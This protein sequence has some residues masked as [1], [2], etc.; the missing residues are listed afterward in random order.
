MLWHSKL[1][2]DS[3]PTSKANPELMAH[4]Q[5]LPHH[6]LLAAHPPLVDKVRL[7]ADRFQSR[8][9]PPA[10]CII[11][12]QGILAALLPPL[13]PI[14]PVKL[15]PLPGFPIASFRFVFGS[16]L[17]SSTREARRHGNEDHSE[18][19]DLPLGFQQ[20]I[21]SSAALFNQHHKGLVV[22]LINCMNLHNQEAPPPHYFHSPPKASSIQV[23]LRRA[24]STLSSI[25]N[26]SQR[27]NRI[28]AL[29]RQIVAIGLLK[30][31]RQ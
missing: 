27:A 16:T 15:L 25:P 17:F 24:R 13:G 2:L 23:H 6:Q 10:C 22:L 21:L 18:G 4:D 8:D 31:S 1:L 28:A 19:G 29:E 9:L 7:E 11:G 14:T 20:R 5:L 12:S 3:G 30:P 26:K